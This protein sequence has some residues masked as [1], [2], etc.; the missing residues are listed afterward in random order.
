L[1]AQREHQYEQL[2]AQ[3]ANARKL[4]AD[5]RAELAALGG[6]QDTA[7]QALRGEKALLQEQLD[8]ANEERAQLQ[9]DLASMKRDTESS[10]A[11]E[12]AENALLRERI[13]D[14]AAE[15]ARLTVA[16]EGS[17][18]PI[19]AM[20]AS[21]PAT[22]APPRATNGDRRP[23]GAEGKGNLADRIRALQMK[24]SRVPATS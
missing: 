17:D 15:I 2:N 21:E 6:R 14:I 12:R 1:L 23:A 20:L 10:W 22:G 5:L 7:T 16:L 18:S 24:A 11:A 19:E 4:E 8:K 9:R 13:N 3:L